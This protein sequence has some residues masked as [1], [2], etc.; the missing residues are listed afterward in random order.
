MRLRGAYVLILTHSHA[1]DFALV[2]SA[3]RRDDWRYLGLIGSQS[4]R[5]QF[6]KRLRHAGSTPA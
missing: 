5:N 3:L 6:E 4:K 1:L 2:E